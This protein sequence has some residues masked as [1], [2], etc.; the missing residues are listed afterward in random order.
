MNMHRPHRK[1]DGVWQLL[2]WSRTK[3]LRRAPW[4][5]VVRNR[6]GGHEPDTHARSG[7]ICGC[8]GSGGD[9]RV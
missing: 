6:I 8:L 2:A 1:G 4:R 7:A 3:M 5:A 9:R